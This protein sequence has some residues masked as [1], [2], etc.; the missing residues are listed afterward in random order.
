MDAVR[1]ALRDHRLN[2]EQCIPLP[3]AVS[4]VRYSDRRDLPEQLLAQ[5]SDTL[6]DD[7]AFVS[8]VGV[9]P[10]IVEPIGIGVFFDPHFPL[11]SL[12][13]DLPDYLWANNTM[14]DWWPAL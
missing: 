3:D 7:A 1:V 12:W 9:M 4:H 13:G 5:M 11:R 14:T 6:D 2:R 10:V 8:G